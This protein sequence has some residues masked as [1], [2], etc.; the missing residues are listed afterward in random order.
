MYLRRTDPLTI[1]ILPVH[2]HSIIIHSCYSVTKSCLTVIPWI[3][4]HPAPLSFTF[5][6]SLLKFV[7]MEWVILSNHLTLC[8]PF[9]SCYQSFPASGSSPMSW[10]FTSGGQSIGASASASVLQM[11][12][13]GGF[14]LG[15]TGLI[16]LL[17]KGLLRVFSITIQKH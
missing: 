13:Q 3:V 17:S 15:L 2:E 1:L 9:F 12:I 8:W 14:P 10:L 4:T 16:S 11:S 5:S 6:Q 7:S